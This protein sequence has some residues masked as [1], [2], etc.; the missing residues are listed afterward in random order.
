MG[1]TGWHA[2]QV[3]FK[4]GSDLGKQLAVAPQLLAR[5]NDL[6]MGRAAYVVAC[7]Q[8]PDQYIV[9]ALK[10]RRFAILLALIPSD[11]ARARAG[12]KNDENRRYV[13]CLTLQ[14]QHRW[15]PRT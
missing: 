12:E 15:Q 1:K 8:R 13:N 9:L 2:S 11:P 7:Q 5:V 3:E 4:K 10:V 6:D 14:G